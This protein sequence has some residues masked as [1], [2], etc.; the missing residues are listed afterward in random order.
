MLLEMRIQLLLCDAQLDHCVC[1]FPIDFD[2]LIHPPQIDDDIMIPYRLCC[3]VTPVPT[4]TD[5]VQCHVMGAS[6]LNIP[7]F[8]RRMLDA[9]RPISSVLSGGCTSH[10]VQAI[11]D[12]ERRVGRPAGC[13]ILR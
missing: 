12:L 8:V 13:G 3:T 5:W 1:K 7:R 9:A 11:P 2:D 10:K 4:G 6:D